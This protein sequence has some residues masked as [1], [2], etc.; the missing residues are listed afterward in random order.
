MSENK[1][2][3]VCQD[4]QI[5]NREKITVSGVL[6]ILSSTDKEI[7]LKLENSF[8]QISGNKLSIV[9]LDAQAKTFSANGLIDGLA[10]HA[11]QTKKSFFGK[12]F[13]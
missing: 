7:Y 5:F 11:K 1:I 6:E 3:T 2:V 4:V 9:E 10:Y 8:M 13:K 12:V